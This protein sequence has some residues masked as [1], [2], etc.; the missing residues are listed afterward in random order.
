MS[1]VDFINLLSTFSKNKS[2]SEL[3][4]FKSDIL[5]YLNTFQDFIAVQIF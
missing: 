4:F 5:E 1:E 2:A 3:D